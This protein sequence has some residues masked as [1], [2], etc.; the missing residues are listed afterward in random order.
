M[1]C[2][3]TQDCR[4]RPVSRFGSAKVE[5]NYD[6]EEATPAGPQAQETELRRSSRNL[7]PRMM[8]SLHTTE[9]ACERID[10]ALPTGS[11]LGNIGAV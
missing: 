8:M 3:Q 7:V 4:V 10:L 11:E 1:R 2:S 5:E 6:D 9:A